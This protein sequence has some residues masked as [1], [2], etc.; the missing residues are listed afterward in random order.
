MARRSTWYANHPATAG[1][2]RAILLS[3]AGPTDQQ[4]LRGSGGSVPSR[5]RPSQGASSVPIMAQIVE[6]F[7]VG[8]DRPFR[9][10]LPDDKVTEL[11]AKLPHGAGAISYES[12]GRSHVI[13]VAHITAV[14]FGTGDDQ[15]P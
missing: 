7:V 6:I 1:I 12:G 9:C 10:E 2:A 5:M 11:C 4:N 14:T 3:G 13:R 15:V 8:N